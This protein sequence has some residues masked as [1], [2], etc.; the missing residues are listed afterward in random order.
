MKVAATWSTAATV[1]HRATHGSKRVRAK[2]RNR[3]TVCRILNRREAYVLGRVPALG[4]IYG[5][6]D[7]IKMLWGTGHPK[8]GNRD[9]TWSVGWYGEWHVR[10]DQR[11][12][13]LWSFADLRAEYRV[14]PP[15]GGHWSDPARLVGDYCAS[16]RKLRS[17]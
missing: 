13:P 16:L 4:G 15:Q 3:L 12:R 1:L 5:Q 14:N 2:Y 11:T 7:T 9:R 8:H 17:P 10:V 6:V